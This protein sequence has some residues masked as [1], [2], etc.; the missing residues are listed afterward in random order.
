MGK[1]DECFVGESVSHPCTTE[2][3]YQ[4]PGSNAQAG[5]GDAGHAA[6]PSRL[7]CPV[8][9][10]HRRD[11]DPEQEN[12]GVHQHPD[13]AGPKHGVGMQPLLY[14]PGAFALNGHGMRQ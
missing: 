5:T 6:L 10:Q 11:H 7:Q 1:P 4:E 8:S 3:E 9:Q 14:H 12:V 2:Y 13:K